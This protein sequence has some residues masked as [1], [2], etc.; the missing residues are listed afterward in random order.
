MTP[1]KEKI[2]LKKKVQILKSLQSSP[3]T[4]ESL[5]EYLD[6]AS[7]PELATPI[8][9]KA[10]DC[11]VEIDSQ[12]SAVYEITPEEQWSRLVLAEAAM[13]E[14]FELR[15]KIDCFVLYFN[16]FRDKVAGL[17]PATVLEI[18]TPLFC[19]KTRNV[20]FL[21]FSPAKAFPR[22]F[23]GAL[24]EQTLRSPSVY[25]PFSAPSWSGS[26]STPA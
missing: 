14:N 3:L 15:T 5:Q 13:D 1:H 23:F 22:E 24:L 6:Y 4:P 16:A 17:P 9:K 20:Q 2:T 7:L 26:A 21:V 25:A 11:L 8:L 18:L 19:V 10:L 12:I